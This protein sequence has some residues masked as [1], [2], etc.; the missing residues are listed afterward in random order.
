MGGVSKDRGQEPL[1]V[2]PLDVVDEVQRHLRILNDI[3]DSD[4]DEVERNG[5]RVRV[6]E[7]SPEELQ[8]E[9]SKAMDLINEIKSRMDALQ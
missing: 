8:L 9:L 2:S 7:V 1:D 4:T 3:A 6:E 5:R